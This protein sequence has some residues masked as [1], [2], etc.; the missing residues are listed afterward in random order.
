MSEALDRLLEALWEKRGEM[1]QVQFA[2]H[3][4]VAQTSVSSLFARRNPPTRRVAA[5][6]VTRYPELEPLVVAVMRES[7][8]AKVA[9]ELRS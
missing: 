5:G 4:G 9:E 3:L 7:F 8:K 6:I 2:A 1:T